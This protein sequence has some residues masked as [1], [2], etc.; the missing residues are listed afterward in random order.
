[1]LLTIATHIDFLLIDRINKQPRLAIE[2]DGWS[3]HRANSVQAGRDNMKN[4]ILKKLGLPLIRVSTNESNI[5]QRII[6]QLELL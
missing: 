5:S 1:M 2:V 3:F 4:E 6:R